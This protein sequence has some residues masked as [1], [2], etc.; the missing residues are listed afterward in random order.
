MSTLQE[1]HADLLS[2]LA[3]QEVELTVVRAALQ[4]R[5]DADELQAVDADARREVTA[6]YGSYTDF[7]QQ[8]EPSSD[9]IVRSYVE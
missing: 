7:R 3:Q 2:L 4:C 6:L 5:V 8:E 9:L 1:Q